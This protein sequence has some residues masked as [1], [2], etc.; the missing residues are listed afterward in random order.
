MARLST[1]EMAGTNWL[2]EKNDDVRQETDGSTI[3]E[4]N[5]TQIFSNVCSF[6]F[7][8]GARSCM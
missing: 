5:D 7:V 3:S 6:Y 1:S 2:T 4:L 8:S